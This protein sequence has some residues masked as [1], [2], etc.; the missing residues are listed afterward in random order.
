MQ[1]QRSYESIGGS[2]QW[3]ASAV[4]ENAGGYATALS[5][6]YHQWLALQPEF[7][8]IDNKAPKKVKR[9]DVIWTDEGPVLC[10]TAPQYKEEMNRPIKY[11]VY[12][13]V[14]GEKIN[15]DDATKIV[16]FTQS[17]FFPLIYQGGEVKYIYVVTT[18]DRL[19][20]ESK[21]QKQKIRL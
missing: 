13:F 20:N 19:H 2:C 21:A 4:A 14:K 8:F 10:W 18:L 16:G 17:T 11:V 15:L 1:L 12:R 5:K 3:P 6:E 9:L 7:S